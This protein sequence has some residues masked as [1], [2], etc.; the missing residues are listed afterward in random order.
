MPDN[1][2]SERIKTANFNLPDNVASWNPLTKLD[3]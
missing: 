3:S 1:Y 2:E